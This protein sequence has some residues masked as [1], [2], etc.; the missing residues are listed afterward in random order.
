M[1]YQIKIKGNLDQSWFD[2]LG[3]VQ[4]MKEIAEDGSVFTTL[5]LDAN[6]QPT[7]FGILDRIR[8]LNLILINVTCQDYEAR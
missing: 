6:D 3:S 5:T 7:L 8:D 1:V 2:W 4:M